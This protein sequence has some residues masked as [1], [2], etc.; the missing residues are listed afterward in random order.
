MRHALRTLPPAAAL[1]LALA[2][3]PAWSQE[4]PARPPITIEE[5]VVEPARPAADT[6]CRLKV[7]LKNHGE[8]IG[9]Q[10]GFDVTINGQELIVYRNQLFMYPLE[11]GAESELPLYNFWSTETSRPMPA[12]G[13]LKLEISLR[14]ARW[15]DISTDEE[16]VEVWQPIGP[17]EGLPAKRSLVVE[18][19][20]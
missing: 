2:G 14:E 12:D 8:Q 6:L 15:F 5:I 20:K 1:L 4:E 13:K 9:S 18:M 3:P 7:R 11:P 19:E 10:L 16:G 17:A